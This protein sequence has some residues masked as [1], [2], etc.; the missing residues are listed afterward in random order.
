MLWNQTGVSSNSWGLFAVCTVLYAQSLLCLNITSKTIRITRQHLP[1]Y[2]LSI[3]WIDLHWPLPGGWL[4]CCCC[5]SILSINWKA[6]FWHSFRSRCFC[7]TQV[8]FFSTMTL[9]SSPTAHPTFIL[10][11][12]TRKERVSSIKVLVYNSPPYLISHQIFHP[13]PRKIFRHTTISINPTN[14]QRFNT[15]KPTTGWWK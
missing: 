9:S 10:I 1:V 11:V 7:D 15:W 13:P 6:K 5:N 3:L 4:L 14:P 8:I 12:M 2:T